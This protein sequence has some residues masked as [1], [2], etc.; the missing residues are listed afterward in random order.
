LQKGAGNRGREK[1][2]V[3]ATIWLSPHRDH[4]GL[5]Y[6]TLVDGYFNSTES[7]AY[8]RQLLKALKG[9]VIVVWDGGSMHKGDLIR[10]L[11]DQF[12]D[13]LTL[14][15][16][17]PYAPMLNPVESLWSWM[18]YGQLSNFPP[19]NEWQM[20]D[21]AIGL[22]EEAKRD[23]LRLESIFAASDLPRPVPLLF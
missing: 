11:Q 3:A 14:E 1:V 13:R 17:P 22:L 7:T 2:S 16:L 9:N 19:Q 6:Q 12:R 18:K 21:V 4:L 23:Q 20:N 8:V 10:E 15:K 5:H